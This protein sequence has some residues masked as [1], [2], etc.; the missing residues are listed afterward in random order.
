[1]YQ[2]LDATAHNVAVMANFRKQDAEFCR[3]L[4]LAIQRGQELLSYKGGHNARD[5]ET[6]YRLQPTLI[7]VAPPVVLKPGGH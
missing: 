2:N 1:M 7:T 3:R 6:Y 4:L 5:G